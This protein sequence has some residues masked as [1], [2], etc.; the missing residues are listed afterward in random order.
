MTLARAL[1]SPQIERQR[2][3]TSKGFQNAKKENDLGKGAVFPTAKEADEASDGADAADAAGVRPPAARHAAGEL[4]QR[5]HPA[6]A[7]AE[8]GKKTAEGED[9]DKDAQKQQAEEEDEEDDGLVFRLSRRSR[10]SKACGRNFRVEELYPEN[11]S[12]SRTTL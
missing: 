2:N 10:S 4:R 9:K 11:V 8:A 12:G 6:A 1:S 7:A 3:P 5:L